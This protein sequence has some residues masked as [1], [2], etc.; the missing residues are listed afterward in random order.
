MLIL[1]KFEGDIAVIE[2]GDEMLEVNRELISD[3]VKEGDVLLKR[4]DKYFSDKEAT[5]NRRE[6]IKNLQNSL[7]G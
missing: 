3:D 1:E 4:D 6:Q 5:I 7:W 2:N